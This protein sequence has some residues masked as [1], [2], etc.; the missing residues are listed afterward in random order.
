MNEQRHMPGSYVILAFVAIGLMSSPALAAIE[1]APGMALHN[2]GATPALPAP[3][4][5]S[6]LPA[7]LKS[8]DPLDSLQGI[9]VEGA[10]GGARGL[11]GVLNSWVYRDTSTQKLTFA[12][13][14]VMS[15]S[16]PSRNTRSLFSATL[17]NG[18]G[19]D[20]VSW[21]GVG[22]AGAGADSSGKSIATGSPQWTDGDPSHIARESVMQGSA[23]IDVLKIV[24]Y[25]K[26][27]GTFLNGNSSTGN[28]SS[29]IWFQTDAT[30][31]GVGSAGFLDSGA[32]SGASYLGPILVPEPISAVVWTGLLLLSCGVFR[33]RR[34]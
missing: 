9:L 25:E 17:G 21:T 6:G 3:H 16:S 18:V 12:Y 14:L 33:Q 23:L 1:L 8:L 26:P 4:Y 32:V 5:Q 31:W 11:A 10:M 7:N 19:T 29:L 15:P 22:I 24:W 27:N 2:P 30:Q 20:A 34:S 13:Q 28:T